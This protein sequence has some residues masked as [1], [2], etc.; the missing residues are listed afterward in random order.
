MKFVINYHTGVKDVVEVNSLE[1]AKQIAVEGMTYTQQ[2]VTI[3]QEDGEVLATSYWFGVAPDEDDAVLARFG[4][5]G[6]YQLWDD[7]LAVM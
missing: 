4:D 1:E 5:Y 3:E 7:E 6:F 2:K